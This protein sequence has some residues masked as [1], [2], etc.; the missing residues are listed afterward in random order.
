MIQGILSGLLTGAVGG[1]AGLFVAKWMW[2]KGW[3]K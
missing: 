1:T 2:K 3:I